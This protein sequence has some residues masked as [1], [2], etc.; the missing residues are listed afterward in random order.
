MARWPVSIRFT[1]PDF[2][3][4]SSRFHVGESR[5]HARLGPLTSADGHLRH[6]AHFHTCCWRSSWASSPHYHYFRK[7]GRLFTAARQ[8]ALLLNFIA[9][10]ITFPDAF[11]GMLGMRAGLH[12]R[13][14]QM[15]QHIYSVRPYMLAAATVSSY[16]IS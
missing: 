4:A 14:G 3:L 12:L 1:R 11:L 15:G 8:L 13:S 7:T 16:T 6:R 2:A 5:R 10:N 9:M